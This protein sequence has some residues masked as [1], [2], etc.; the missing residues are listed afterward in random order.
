MNNSIACFLQI[1]KCISYIVVYF[2][3]YIGY[4]YT[5][6]LN[7][8]DEFYFSNK[9]RIKKNLYL[10][11][12]KANTHQ[13]DITHKLTHIL[14]YYTIYEESVDYIFTNPEDILNENL[15]V[16]KNSR[17]I[18]INCSQIFKYFDTNYI[19][20][21]YQILEYNK[22]KNKNYESLRDN[23]EVNLKFEPKGIYQHFDRE[24]EKRIV[25]MGRFTIHLDIDKIEV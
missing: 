3:I 13:H 22:H 1:C 19:S 5:F 6:F 15:N 14:K 17:K 16:P 18:K 9:I 4:L 12:K 7:L 23:I 21:T 8:P 2:K 24:E 10:I 20:F 11:I 25:P